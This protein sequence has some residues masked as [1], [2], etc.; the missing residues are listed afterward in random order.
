MGTDMKAKTQ[1]ARIK[2]SLLA[3]EYAVAK[4]LGECFCDEGRRVGLP[5][6]DHCRRLRAAWDNLKSVINGI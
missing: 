6:C 5:E 1:K 2:A 3:V 4:M